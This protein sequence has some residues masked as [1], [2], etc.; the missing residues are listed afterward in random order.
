V[1][2]ASA[3]TRPDEA[4]GERFAL[5]VGI[6]AYTKS[7]ERPWEPL[8]GARN[9]VAGMRQWLE[10]QDFDVLELVDDAATRDA[11]VSAFEQHLGQAGADDLALFYFAGHGARQADTSGDETDE[12]DEVLALYG[13]AG[14]C[15]DVHT[16]RDDELGELI[17]G[18]STQRVVVVVDSC[19][20]GSI[21][22]DDLRVRGGR[23]CPPS[24]GAPTT[25]L[26]EARRRRGDQVVITATRADEPAAELDA[27]W[28]DVQ[29]PQGAFTFH[30]LNVLRRA[31]PDTSW[32]RVVDI[33]RSQIRRD[34]LIQSPQIEGAAA[35]RIGGLYDARP[36]PGVFV[37]HPN[38]DGTVT[39]EGGILSGLRRADRLTAVAEGREIGRVVVDDA[40]PSTSLATWEPAIASAP[41]VFELRLDGPSLS[42]DAGDVIATGALARDLAQLGVALRPDGRRH[43]DVLVDVRNGTIAL[44]QGGRTIP[45]PVGCD[46]TPVDSIPASRDDAAVLVARAVRLHR[47]RTRL[48]QLENRAYG[49]ADVELVVER[50]DAF[51]DEVERRPVIR[52]GTRA[53]LDPRHPTLGPGETFQLSVVNHSDWPLYVGIV[54][55]T[56]EG[57]IELLYPFPESSRDETRLWPGGTLRLEPLRATTTRGPH[58][59]RLVATAEPQNLRAQYVRSVCLG[60]GA[61]HTRGVDHASDLEAVFAAPGLTRTG[62]AGLAPS[63]G[64]DIV[65]V[66]IE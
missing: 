6:D 33:V 31:P 28:D 36:E 22:R 53:P 21:T 58:A 2:T 50:V 45:I 61:E 25:A 46:A 59:F 1:A 10:T 41:D 18:L 9:D 48:E 29:A 62:R 11:V 34:G 65:Y 39:I 37:G 20:S 14:P 57:G 32:R 52:A 44:S 27:G 30:L 26:L 23:A 63:W 64:T 4:V 12:L 16:L 19:F 55:L 42:P 17:E 3:R 49:A 35:L 66:D 43:R 56:A 54:G 5:L 15:D 38:R 8:Q 13:S 47:S 7:G 51:F 24:R 60:R 40:R